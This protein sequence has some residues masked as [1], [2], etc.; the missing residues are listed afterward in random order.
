MIFKATIEDQSTLYYSCSRVNYS[1]YCSAILAWLHC[2]CCRLKL[3]LFFYQY[4]L[5]RQCH[6]IFYLYFFHESNPPGPLINRL[7]WFCLKIHFREDIQ[8]QNSKFK[9][10]L[11]AVSHCDCAGHVFR[12]YLRENEFFRD[13]ILDCLSGTQMGWIN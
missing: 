5:K 12:E 13:T 7:K 1:M 8:I 6:E 9:V 3:I 2:F 10:R 4:V 11:C